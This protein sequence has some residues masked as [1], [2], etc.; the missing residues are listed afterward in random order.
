VNAVLLAGGYGTR[1]GPLGEDCPKALL[2]V[3]GFTV[4][5]RLLAPL[6]A[7]AEV[8]RLFL[9]TNSRFAG[10]FRDWL[11]RQSLRKP[12]EILDDGSRCNEDRRGA[13]G[14]LQFVLDNTDVARDAAYVLSTD[15]VPGFDLRGII[16]LHRARGAS[17][18]FACREEHLERLRRGGVAELDD[19]DRVV[20]FEEKPQEPLSHYRVPSFYVYTASALRLVRGFLRGGGNSDAPGHFLAWLVKRADVYALRC[21]QGSMDIGT[22]ASYRAACEAG[23]G[24]GPRSPDASV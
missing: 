18:V 11:T 10:R 21:E 3:A 12:L 14:D 20:R 7:A 24:G 4:I 6:E 16:A 9:V 8:R 17:A 23:G 19:D 22:P 2:L 5:D 15:N 13:I 1:L